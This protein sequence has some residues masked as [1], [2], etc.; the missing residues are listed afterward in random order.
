M[1][2]PAA[3]KRPKKNEKIEATKTSHNISLLP[4]PKLEYERTIIT[5]LTVTTIALPALQK[6]EKTG[7]L[8]EETR[9]RTPKLSLTCLNKIGS[10][11]FVSPE[12]KAAQTG[13]AA[14]YKT[15]YG[16]IS[17]QNIFIMMGKI[18]TAIIKKSA[19]SNKIKPV[20]NREERS[21]LNCIAQFTET[22]IS[23]I[24][25]ISTK[26]TITE[27]ATEEN[28]SNKAM[29]GFETFLSTAKPAPANPAKIQTGKRYKPSVKAPNELEG[30]RLKKDSLIPSGSMLYASSTKIGIIGGLLK[31][32]EIKPS[33]A[34]IKAEA[35]TN[36]EIYAA[37]LSKP[38][39]SLIL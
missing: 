20:K 28:E 36:S 8:T 34:A 21:D 32:T 4:I 31:M 23:P 15:L 2:A 7:R 1:Y 10:V 17:L 25:N 26:K 30:K 12:K 6:M 14:A 5:K 22:A 9:R 29:A 18:I 13:A 19:E 39:D 16:L 11:T 27:Y 3:G 24:E 35:T 33:K 38:L 37:S